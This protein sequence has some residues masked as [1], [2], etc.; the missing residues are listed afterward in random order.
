MILMSRTEVTLI[1]A[2]AKRIGV[3]IGTIRC[4]ERVGLMLLPPRNQGGH[5]FYDD[6]HIR[7]LRF[8]RRS[9]ELGFP[10]DKIRAMLA[11]VDDS[12]TVCCE[13]AKEIALRHLADVHGQITCLRKLERALKNMTDCCR[14]GDQ[15]SCPIIEALSASAGRG[16]S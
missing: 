12:S 14:P 10:L 5:R 3:N 2:L 6:E 7:R 9:R 16:V 13:T 11:L 15:S 8:I 1:G 4:Y